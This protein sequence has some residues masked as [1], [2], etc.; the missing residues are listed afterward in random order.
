M[1]AFF[2]CTCRGFASC[3]FLAGFSGLKIKI[4]FT[5]KF[6]SVYEKGRC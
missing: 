6:R 3:R 4:N 2:L 5:A 1:E